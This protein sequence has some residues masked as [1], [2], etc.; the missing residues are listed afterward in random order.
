MVGSVTTYVA[1]SLSLFSKEDQKRKGALYVVSI[2]N[3]IMIVATAM[4]SPPQNWM[5]HNIE[6]GC[7][8]PIGIY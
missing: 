5:Q 1:R 3:L 4:L 8:P 7:V 2:G 6:N